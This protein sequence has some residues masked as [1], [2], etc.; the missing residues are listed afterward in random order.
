MKQSTRLSSAVFQLTPTR[1][2]CDLIITANDK[3]E[4]IASGLLNPFIAHLKTAQDQISKGGYSILLEPERSS[5]AAW[6]T[7]ATLERSG[8]NILC[9]IVLFVRFVSTPEILERVFSIETEIF[10]IEEAI[11]IQSRS[12]SAQKIVE[13]HGRKTLGGY[14][15]DKSL[16]NANEEKAIVLYTPGTTLSEANGSCSHDENSRVQLLKVLETRRNVLQKEQGMAFARAVAAGFDI[17]CMA[18]L[19]S[20]AEC[21]G[22]MRLMK[23]CSRFMDL[24]KSKHEKGQWLNIEASE[25]LSAQSDFGAIN[26]SGIILSDT[27]N[28]HDEPNHELASQNF[29]KSGSSNNVD[30]P[31]PN[32][33]Q[34]YFQGQFPH[35]VFPPWPMHTQPGARPVFPA[36]PLPGVPYYQTYTGNGPVFQPHHYP[37]EHSSSNLRPHSGQERQSVDVRDS[38]SGSEMTVRTRSSN[39]MVSDAEV[40]H[41]R[42][43]NKKTG[44][45]KKKQSGKVVIQNINYFTPKAN[46]S[47]SET[48]SDSQPDTE[49]E[50]DYSDGNDVIHQNKKRS[51][52]HEGN[53]ANIDEVSIHGKDSDIRHWQTFQ[54]CLL[55]GSDEGAHADNEGMFMMERGVKMKRYTNTAGEDPLPL[56][57]RDGG[58]IR[59]DRMENMHR[60]EGSVSH[61]LRGLGDDVTFSSADNYLRVN[62][63]QTDIEFAASSF[64]RAIHNIDEDSSHRM[65]DETLVVPFRSMSLDPVGGTDRT[66]IDIDAE[67]SA[68]YQKLG[69]EGSKNKVNYGANDLSLMPERETDK[70]S[71]GYDI[72]L[73]YEVQVGA[74]VSDEKGKQNFTDVKSGLSKSDKN[75]RSNVATD[76]LHKQRTGGPVRK[77]KPSKMSPLEDARARAERLRSYK[78]DLQKMKKEKEEIEAKRLESLKLERQKR[79]AARVGSSSVKPST[80]SPQTKQLPAK[81]SAAANRGSKFSDSEPGS[82]SP[83]QRSKI[84]ISVGSSESYKAAK[85]SKLSEGSHMA[86]NRLTRSSSSLYEKKRENNGVTPDSKASMSRIRRSSE[87]RTIT[88]SPVIT[89]KARNAEIVSK[90][91][92]SEGYERNKV[93]DIIDLD[94]SK[95][96]TL[97]ELKIKMSKPHVNTGENRSE[98]KDRHTIIGVRPYVF[99]KNADLNVSKCNT[100]HQIDSDDNPIVEKTVL[101]LECEG[102]TSYSSK[103]QQSNCD[104]GDKSKIISE[105][106]PIYTSPSPMATCG[107]HNEVRTVYSEKDP[108]AF[109]DITPAENPHRTPHAR[110]S[111]LEDP[112]TH[113][114]EY[115]K[116]PVGSTELLSRAEK[117]VKKKVPDVK[118]LKTDKNQLISEKISAKETSKGFI[119]LLKFG[120]KNHTSLSVDQSIDLECTDGDSIEHDDNARNLASASAG[121]AGEVENTPMLG[122]GGC[123]KN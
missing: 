121:E 39:D 102:A 91:K 3:K 49:A 104:K 55:R 42:K 47:D 8:C 21:F 17:D 81:L 94:R 65:S 19:V 112:Y 56:C 101:V 73:E 13:S 72:G 16:P 75:R 11:A 115:I 6:F 1:T 79:I 86:G 43:P 54:D 68:K 37:M 89:V 62:K 41:G 118:A 85:G 90:R 114:T 108:P 63:N 60:I 74:Q 123:W 52:G 99:P 105:S 122:Q 98:L 51:S 35:I 77:A 107:K 83:L 24:W 84:R 57:A 38:N 15:G 29:G 27:L 2:R 96:A 80:V 61:R 67:I 87:P 32:S 88:K 70:R 93:T 69:S 59:D 25:A 20:F 95:A 28:K 14:E 103:G 31:V 48:N 33:Q 12:D 117:I 5:D 111:S 100:S 4:K 46:K 64:E 66:T 113:K 30:N 26:A 7:K 116:A 76:S 109:A 22:A 34:E 18:H 71:I 40:S 120:K 110:V 9:G 53:N 106:A 36:Y 23:A 10:E 97:P 92:L 58:E 44:G 82:S 78:A 45:S 50:N 119:R